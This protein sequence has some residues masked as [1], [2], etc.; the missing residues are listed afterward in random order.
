VR[1]LRT[2]C[3]LANRLPIAPRRGCDRTSDLPRVKLRGSQKRD[4]CGGQTG[5]IGPILRVQSTQSERRGGCGADEN[6]LVIRSQ[7][8]RV[9]AG[10]LEFVEVGRRGRFHVPDR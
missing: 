9:E 6:K 5:R 2:G 1:L 10:V 4:A 3:G 8:R 7:I